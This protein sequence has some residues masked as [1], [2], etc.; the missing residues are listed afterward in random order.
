MHTHLVPVLV[1]TA[2]A[3]FGADAGEPSSGCGRAPPTAALAQVEVAGRVRQAIVVPPPAYRSDRA[4]PLVF[5]FHGRTTSNDRARDYFGLEVPRFPA[6]LVYPAALRDASGGFT[7]SD[8]GDPPGAARDF[9]LFDALLDRLSAAYCVDK[10]AV[11]V[12]GHS[13]GASFANSLA[14]ARADR[15]RGLASVAGGIVGQRCVGTVAA[16][17]LHNPEDRAVPLT[18]GLRA[19]TMLLGGKPTGEP[20]LLMQ[21]AFACEQDRGGPDPLLWCLHHDSLTRRGRFYPHQWPPAAGATIMSFFA[22]LPPRG[23]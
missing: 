12:I 23:P 4:Y 8:P 22:D 21:G 15:I 2:L 16:L 14:C 19:R 20:P 6:I 10:A 1:V 18:E 17:L 5:A 11:F 3:A 7:W 13:L 9:A